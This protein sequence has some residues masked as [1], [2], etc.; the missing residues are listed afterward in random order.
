MHMDEK[1]EFFRCDISPKRINLYEM[2]CRIRN[3]REELGMEL[4]DVAFAT[5]AVEGGI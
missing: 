3:R 5:R 4:A 2:G 1:N